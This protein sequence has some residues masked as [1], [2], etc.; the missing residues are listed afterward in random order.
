MKSEH[1]LRNR[2][3]VLCFERNA[4]FNFD[5][6]SA[7]LRGLST[8]ALRKYGLVQVHFDQK[9]YLLHRDGKP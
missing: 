2:L 3:F 9:P 4:A 6:L 7:S 1:R 5:I 8:L